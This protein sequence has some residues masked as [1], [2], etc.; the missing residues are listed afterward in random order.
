MIDNHTFPA[1]W[2]IFPVIFR[3]GKLEV[4]SYSFFVLLGLIV[5][6]SVYF[7][8]ARRYKQASENSFYVVVAGVVGGILGAK[9]P[10]WI[11]NY[12][13]IVE[14]YPNIGPILSGRTITGGLIGGTLSV[15][16][17]K[18]RLGITDK[19]GN[20]FAPAIA[21]GVAIGRLGCF[22]RGCC[23]GEPTTLLCGVN[24]GDDVLR[25]PTQLYE[26]VFFIG[27]FIYSLI[28][29]KSAPPGFLFYALMNSYF[30]LR[31]FEEFIRYN[32]QFFWGL[33]FFQ[34]ISIVA[35]VFIN[36]KQYLEKT[37]HH[38]RLLSTK[39]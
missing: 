32:D 22:A 24:F 5:G 34:Y 30:I 23:Y 15:I 27:F 4:S 36:L 35:V 9:L 17:I 25:H 29:I 39:R 13:V 10:Y 18:R 19:K 37:Q 31:F 33:S 21:I 3:I 12:Q 38:G 8:L 6:L 7:L 11:F 14:N 2:G 1:N 16:Y 20:L 28:R 26:T